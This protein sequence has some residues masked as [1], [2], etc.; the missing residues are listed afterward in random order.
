MAN[1]KVTGDL[2]ASSTIATGNI[3]DNAVTSDKIS[4]IT[5][6]HIAEGSN[7][8]YTDARADA[9][10]ALIVDSAPAT[11][12]TLNE[13]AAALGDDPN[14]ATTTATSIGLK[15]PIASPSFTGNAT[16]AG[17]ITIGNNASIKSIG[18]V[19]IDIDED[20]NS[21][22]RAFL[23]RNNGG[24]NT[25]FRVQEDGSVGIGTDSPSSLLTLEET[26]TNSVQLV[27]DNNNTSDAGTETSKIRFRHYRSYVAGLNDAGE[28]TVGK[29]E[30]WDA[31]GDRNSY[32]S[33][34]TRTGTS[35]V[36]EKMRIDSSGNVGI[37]GSPSA[38][39]LGKTIQINGSY[40]TINYN[41]GS[42]AILGIVNAYYN[43]SAYIRQN[44]GYAGSIDYN[45]AKL[46]GFAFRTENSTG[47]A[48]DTVSLSTKMVIDASGKVG[49]GTTSP[50]QKLHLR[51]SGATSVFAQ[52]GNNSDSKNSYLGLTAGGSFAM[53]TND[54][55]RFYTGASYTERMRI[56]SSGTTRLL[57]TQVT[58]SFDTTSF[59]RLHPS[60]TINNGGF[61]NMFFGTSTVDNYGISLGG[62]RA[63]AS[64]SP[65]FIIKTHNNDATGVERMRIEA[66]GGIFFPSL[67]GF[68][69]SNS[70]VRYNA[71]SDELYYQTSSKRY[72]SEITDLE[73]SLDKINN[74]RPVRFKDN[75][76]QEYATGMIAEEV[77][78]TIPEVVFTK[79]IDGF[80]EPQIEGINYSDLVP[81]LIKSIQELKADN[82]SLRARIETLENN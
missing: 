18:S 52:W 75:L 19:R 50:S 48:G 37:G 71:T 31:S 51:E 21:T 49:I 54:D 70:D 30:A 26:D 34:S 41:S 82:D 43:G 58:G 80:D 36:T 66:D 62:L 77:A 68:S 1:T 74:L 24:A 10:V 16:F 42:G 60:T 14:F 6:A 67:G 9:R 76:S 79:P 15:A 33:F 45:L 8:Y 35:G 57:K 5:T 29:E 3:A 47:S 39:A 7:L 63:G 11:L 4:G 40:G 2:I 12:D 13:L 28:I 23:V 59:L 55:I 53:Q 65:T 38:W 22:T 46:G 61:T 73:N 56:D 78:E 20:N 69:V 44:A 17:D 72:K 81:F 32:M 25:L 27:I 64:G